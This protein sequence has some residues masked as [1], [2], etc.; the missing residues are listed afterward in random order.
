MDLSKSD[1]V[2]DD[3]S[4]SEF[5][6]NPQEVI[7][8]DGNSPVRPRYE[9]RAAPRL[10]KDTPK[11]T[12]LDQDNS[13]DY[14]A[15]TEAPRPKSGLVRKRRGSTCRSPQS[16]APLPKKRKASSVLRRQSD[17]TCNS[18]STSGK[19]DN[20]LEALSADDFQATSPE[21]EGLVSKVKP[22]TK[23]IT[24]RLAHPIQFNCRATEFDTLPCHWCDRLDF[25]ICGLSK[26]VVKVIDFQDKMGYVEI[27]GGHN[28]EGSTPS[29]MCIMCTTERTMK[30]ACKQHQLVEYRTSRL[31]FCDLCHLPADWACRPPGDLK[32]D[33][34][35]RDKSGCGLKLCDPHG[36]AIMRLHKGNLDEM[37]AEMERKYALGYVHARADINLLH[38]EGLMLGRT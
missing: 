19:E 17:M 30:I 18:V 11:S 13:G 28:E 15:D 34:A 16:T 31:S 22:V 1:P 36:R 32:L 20:I 10:P 33:S 29:K 4:I 24:T 23:T 9:F 8:A 27:K 14:D 3:R 2:A 25:G 37:I 35:S 38:S 6:F 5:T 21:P 7:A 12:Y 26:R